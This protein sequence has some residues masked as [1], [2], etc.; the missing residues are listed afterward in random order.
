MK[1]NMKV[2]KIKRA[3]TVPGLGNELGSTGLKRTGDRYSSI[4]EEF[5]REL[6]GE[7]AIRIFREM[8]DN[9]P[10]IGA[11]FFAIEMLA[12]KVVWR[13]DGED[14]QAV[15]FV[16]SCTQDMSSTWEDVVC[17]ILS[18]LT[19]GFSFHEIVYKKR[20]GD[21]NDPEH[22]SRF[23][24]GKIGWR[25]LP[26]RSQDSLIWWNFDTGGGIQGVTQVAPPDYQQ[27]EIPIN[28]GLL[29][30]MGLHKGSPEGRSLLRNAYRPWFIKK[31]VEEIEAI[32]IER[33]L[34]GI[35]LF[36]LDPSIYGKY[37]SKL[38]EIG[39]TLKR[40]EQECLILPL[41][42]DSTGKNK[43][44]TFELINSG[45]QRQL[46]VSNT[47]D[48][49][50]RRIAMT[51]L[52]DFL[53]LGQG[54]K[55]GG[56]Y[57]LVNSRDELFSRAMTSVLDSIASVFNRIAIPRL[58]AIN[59]MALD[60][61]PQMVPGPIEAP[62]LDE[63]SKFVS[64]LAQAGMPLFPDVELENYLRDA[65]HLPP[66]NEATASLGQ[67]AHHANSPVLGDTQPAVPPAPSLQPGQRRANVP[68]KPASKVPP[69]PPTTN[70]P[71]GEGPA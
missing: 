37:E 32:G 36:Y 50:D 5:L 16:E 17:E 42:Y 19:F 30:R 25:K 7:Q 52:A 20:E 56:S 69:V 4:Q 38:K 43:L 55:S 3:A 11:M 22:Q 39:R 48:R 40:D 28:R 53:F 29:F 33:D 21:T 64:L 60:K 71:S 27:V 2:E 44:L 68:A 54:A 49:Y 31:R 47:I 23:N 63:L 59:G 51:V 6:R 13:V 41:L 58:L 12:R 26:I 46:D 70:V 57:A 9:D 65:A 18:M 10:V 45:G 34:A 24:D 1:A 35:P 15:E 14:K 62:G 67:P 8:R 66:K 61:V